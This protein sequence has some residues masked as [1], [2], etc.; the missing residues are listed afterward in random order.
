MDNL[1]AFFEKIILED[2]KVKH[3][4]AKDWSSYLTS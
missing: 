4:T 2:K 1:N 3:P